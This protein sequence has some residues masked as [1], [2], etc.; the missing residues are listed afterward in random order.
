VTS[1][2]QEWRRWFRSQGTYKLEPVAG[3]RT[4]RTVL[5]ELEVN[6]K[7]LGLVAARMAVSEVRKTYEAEADTLRTL[8]TL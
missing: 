2:R 5:G 8:A 1:P 6:V 7:I 4:R 3:G